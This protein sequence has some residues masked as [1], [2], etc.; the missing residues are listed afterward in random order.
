[1]CQIDDELMVQDPIL[2][3]ATMSAYLDGLIALPFETV[4]ILAEME[5]EKREA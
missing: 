1:M 4:R 3:E 2:E 5:R